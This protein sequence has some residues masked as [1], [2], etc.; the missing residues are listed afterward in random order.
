MYF[1]SSVT[2]HCKGERSKPDKKPYPLA[3]DLRNPETN[4]KIMPKN[5]NEIVRS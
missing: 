2:V 3:F 1:C 4:L 5:L